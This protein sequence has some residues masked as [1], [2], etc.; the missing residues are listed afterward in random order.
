MQCLDATELLLA[1]ERER[2]DDLDQ[3]V[4]GCARCASVMR[5]IGR[6]DVVVH[7]AIVIAPPIDLQRD[8]NRLVWDH[9]AGRPWWQRVLGWADSPSTSPR[10]LAFQGLATMTAA[11][12]GWQVFGAVANVQPVV[13]DTAYALQLV[14]ASP[15]SAYVSGMHLDLQSLGVWSVVGLI[16]WAVSDDGVLAGRLAALR[17][18]LP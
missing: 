6:L 18:R 16:G 5:G 12:V 10:R 15:A 3:H 17:R 1:D 2:S 7:A 8:L 9:V 4:R 14:M 11:V 13:G